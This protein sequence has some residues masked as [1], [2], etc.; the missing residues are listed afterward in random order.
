MPFIATAI[1]VGTA[2][3]G[4]GKALGWWGQ[5]P[6]QRYKKSPEE[7]AYEEELSRRSRE[8]IYSKGTQFNL[9]NRAT[10]ISANVEQSQRLSQQGQAL[11]GGT[12]GVASREAGKVGT[13]NLYRSLVE[14]SLDISTQNELSKIQAQDQA[15]AL[16]QK[17]SEIKNQLR[18]QNRMAE[19]SAKQAGFSQMLTGLSASAGGLEQAFGLADPA[20]ATDLAGVLGKLPSD[21]TEAEKGFIRQ[22]IIK[23]DNPEKMMGYIRQWD[24]DK[25]LNLWN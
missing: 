9:L 7:I 21:V 14:G 5:P 8:G 23:S 25:I 4:A 11:F 6:K 20:I 22:A 15:G 2:I 1:G 3:A 12:R 19:Y 18:N 10:Q 24:S 16:A 17:Y 13:E